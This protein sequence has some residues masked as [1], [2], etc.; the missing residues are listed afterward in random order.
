MGPIGMKRIKN[1]NLKEPAAG[2]NKSNGK[3]KRS[4]QNR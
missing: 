1:V 3:N 4:K 2:V